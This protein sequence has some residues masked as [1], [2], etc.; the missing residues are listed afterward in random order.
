MWTNV[1]KKSPISYLFSRISRISGENFKSWSEIRIGMA[2]GERNSGLANGDGGESG[3]VPRPKFS[4]VFQDFVLQRHN[5]GLKMRDICGIRAWTREKLVQDVR[6]WRFL[7]ARQISANACKSVYA[8]QF[9]H[10]FQF[11]I[12]L[13]CTEI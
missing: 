12:P 1:G 2:N 3:E 8:I 4:P 6:N 5:N 9:T 13:C 10:S 7:S 11:Q